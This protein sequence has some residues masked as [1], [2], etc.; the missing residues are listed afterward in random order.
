MPR[1]GIELVSVALEI[2]EVNGLGKAADVRLR[3]IDAL[4]RD[5]GESNVGVGSC[6]CV[7]CQSVSVGE[8]NRVTR[9]WSDDVQPK[10]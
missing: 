2:T 9:K 6:M 7:T 5:G 10:V 3:R 8:V 1:L 4:Y